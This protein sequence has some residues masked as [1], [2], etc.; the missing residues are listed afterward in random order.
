MKKSFLLL[1]A[2][3]GLAACRYDAADELFPVNPDDCATVV[4]YNLTI[5]PLLTKSCSG[6]HSGASAPA[7]VKFDSHAD[8]KKV[9]SGG[10][11]VGVISH[12]AGFN[13]MPLGGTKL[14]DC[15]I[16]QVQQWVKDGMPD[17]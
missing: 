8:T 7:G 15:N 11:L 16:R 5:R 6:C 13:P 14:S 9:A 17:N 3:T 12:A 10:L 1:F 2:L 4:T